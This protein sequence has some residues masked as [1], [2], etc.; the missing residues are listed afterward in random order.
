MI[1]VLLHLLQ[2]MLLFPHW[3]FYSDHPI[4]WQ[5]FQWKF[6]LKLPQMM[7]RVHWVTRWQTSISWGPLFNFPRICSISTA[8]WSLNVSTKLLRIWKWKA[9]VSSLLRLRQASPVARKRQLPSQADRYEYSSALVM[10]FVLDR[11]GSISS[12]PAMAT[13]GRVPAHATYMSP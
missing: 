2:T 4:L 11:M 8:L 12:G 9:G 5:T 13:I 7:L 6:F 3:S 10:S 1:A